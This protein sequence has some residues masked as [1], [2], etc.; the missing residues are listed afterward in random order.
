MTDKSIGATAMPN[1]LFEYMAAGLPVITHPYMDSIRAWDEGK[2]CVQ[3]GFDGIAEFIKR[4]KRK[5]LQRYAEPYNNLTRV[6]Q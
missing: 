3:F 5:R 6:L 4:T 2:G 1:K